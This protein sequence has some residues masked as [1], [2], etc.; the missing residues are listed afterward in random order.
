MRKTG[1]LTDQVGFVYLASVILTESAI[2]PCAEH[3]EL[4]TRV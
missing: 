4:N 1:K 3:Y 2:K